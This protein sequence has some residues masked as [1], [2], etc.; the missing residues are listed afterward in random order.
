M[1]RLELAL[2]AASLLVSILP[3]A[4]LNVKSVYAADGKAD[5]YIIC[6]QGVDGNLRDPRN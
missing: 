1:K 6:L 2:V 5:V 4:L 3:L